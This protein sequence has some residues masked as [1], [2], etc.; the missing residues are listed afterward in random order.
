MLR[1]MYK[2]SDLNIKDNYKTIF[3]IRCSPYIVMLYYGLNIL[4]SNNV[5]TSLYSSFFYSFVLMLPTFLPNLP[6]FAIYCALPLLNQNL[7][8]SLSNCAQV[9][10]VA[11][12]IG[13]KVDG[14]LFSFSNVNCSFCMLII[15][16]SFNYFQHF[17][18]ISTQTAK[19]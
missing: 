12:I 5:I 3:F 18:G 6:P 19:F 10:R 4:T 16:K 17:K 14:C 9:D 11:I 15:Y 13:A 8:F 2:Y 1:N 7:M